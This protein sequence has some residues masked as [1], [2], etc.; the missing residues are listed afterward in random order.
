MGGKTKYLFIDR[1]GTIIEE[2]DDF[3]VDSLDKVKLV[4]GVIPALLKLQSAG[5]QL[6]M[7]TN[8]DG[9]G[10]DSF[11]QADFDGPHQMLQSILTSQGIQFAAE[12]IDPHFE[13]DNAPTRK[14]GIGM[15]LGYLQSGE[16]DFA[17]SA[18]I[19]DR[20]TDLQLADN[21]GVRGL[22]IGPEYLSWPGIVHELINQP[23][24]ARVERKTSE[25]GIVISVDLDTTQPLSISTGIG[26]F[27][28]ML[29]QLAL[30]GGF[31]ATI[32]AAG[33]LHI[34]EHHTVE[35]VALTLGQALDQALGDRRGIG[36]YGFVVPMDEAQ[37]RVAVDLSGR[38]YYVLRGQ[39]PDTRIGGLSTEMV[40]HFFH[41]LAQ[42]LRAA[43]HI[44]IEGD[45]SHHQVEAMFKGVGR[46]L[47]PA[48]SRGTPEPF[49]IPSSKGLL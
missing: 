3:Q 32:E 10:T 47:R 11:P 12:H 14:P 20:E 6:V 28:H 49:S 45:N 24:T 36:R 48:L 30:H 33:D 15:L 44:H 2:P 7:V 43:I 8:Q 19:G 29:E 22:R 38:P 35:D 37:A 9:L 31:A 26:F 13:H 27:D 41:S 42:T 1:D 25:T 34:D 4:P 5:Y 40:T 39:L 46:A 16:M 23:R 21:L 17:H 18:V